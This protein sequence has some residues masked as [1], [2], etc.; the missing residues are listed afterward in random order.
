M[1]VNHA[2]EELTLLTGWFLSNAV[3][4]ILVMTGIAYLPFAYIFVVA[5][6]KARTQGD[7]EG[8]DGEQALKIISQDFIKV[9]VV[10]MIA[11]FPMMSYQSSGVV[12]GGA[13][14]D[15]AIDDNDIEVQNDRIETVS[16]IAGGT[17]SVPLLWVIVH[18]LSS[19]AAK[20]TIDIIPCEKD[21][22]FY[23]IRFAS[24][25]IKD[26]H[27]QRMA[28]TFVEQCYVPAMSDIS[29]EVSAASGN[30]DAEKD[31]WLGSNKMQDHYRRTT[32][33]VEL[34]MDIWEASWRQSIGDPSVQI[35]GYDPRGDVKLGSPG[36]ATPGCDVFL[37]HLRRLVLA[38]RTDQDVSMMDAIS[39]SWADTKVMLRMSDIQ[40]EQ[41]KKE[42]AYLSQMITPGDTIA[43]PS[44]QKDFY[45]NSDGVGEVV[46][47]GLG[48]TKDLLTNLTVSAGA[49]WDI[50]NKN[51]EVYM[52][53]KML[54]MGLAVVQML[55]YMLIPLVLVFQAYRVATVVILCGVAFA[56]EYMNV[57]FALSVWA[58]KV[59]MAEFMDM[60]TF[61][62]P[63]NINSQA[64]VAMVANITYIAM[65]IAY[66]G[67]LSLAGI[68]INSMT[69][70]SIG[71]SESS[72]RSASS[73]TKA[74]ASAAQKA[75]TKK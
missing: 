47:D 49:G 63:D 60:G 23:N 51:M 2:I 72:S 66:M 74:A 20:A 55:F 13:C 62:N 69:G 18:N 48:L 40:T 37:G 59:F 70:S 50:A 44:Y 56:L 17:P 33:K 43:A 11:V 10:L 36:T 15:P 53:Q 25:R 57:P 28:N 61:L 46:A 7:D 3:W 35:N 29:S 24:S 21:Y 65:P 42:M 19:A 75:A 5:W 41:E 64:A 38:G 22:R 32:S 14:V 58:D 12:Y 6:D 54:P 27:T 68:K 73:G 1:V 39:E 45:F 71:G 34:P 30:V 8:N 4:E 26:P 9:L 16:S 67:I 31:L 52:L